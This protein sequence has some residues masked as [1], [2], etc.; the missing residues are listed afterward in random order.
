MSKAGRPKGESD[1][2]ARLINAARD[3]FTRIP[4]DKVTTRKLADQAH[5]NIAM[6]RY[7]FGNKSG[8]FSEMLKEVSAPIREQVVQALQET[9]ASNFT[10]ILSTYYKAMGPNPTLPQLIFQIM[11]MPDNAEPRKI[12]LE[13]FTEKK[14]GP[15]KFFSALDA[16]SL[17]DGVNPKM[18]WL[19]IQSLMIFPFLIYPHARRAGINIADPEFLE[20]LAE[21]NA[22]LLSQGIFKDKE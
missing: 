19:S 16:G 21:H 8:L 5:V 1:V 22:S 14:D 2:R 12:L 3:L 13:V 15:E 20:Q 9:S 17:Q 4:Y 7:Y 18:A 10:A 11:S 6:I